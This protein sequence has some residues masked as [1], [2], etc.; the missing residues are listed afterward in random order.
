MNRQPMPL[1]FKTFLYAF[2]KEQISEVYN[3]ESQATSVISLFE[4]PKG[5]S[6]TPQLIKI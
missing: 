1:N 5:K 6:A 2:Y 3:T 4:P